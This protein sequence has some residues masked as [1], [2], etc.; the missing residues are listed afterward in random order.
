VSSEAQYAGKRSLIMGKLYKR[1]DE[2]KFSAIGDPTD[3]TFLGQ[4][5]ARIVKSY[6]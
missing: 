3:D 5:I 2:W 6:L 1:N 4:T